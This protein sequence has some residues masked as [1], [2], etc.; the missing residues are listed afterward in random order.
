MIPGLPWTHLYSSNAKPWVGKSQITTDSKRIKKHYYTLELTP[1][2]MI[3]PD[4]QDAELNLT[5]LETYEAKDSWYILDS[6]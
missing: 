5:T 6:N 1:K 3:E 2:Y 4:L